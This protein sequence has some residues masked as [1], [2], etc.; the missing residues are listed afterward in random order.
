MNTKTKTIDCQFADRQVFIHYQ[1]PSKISS[2]LQKNQ[3]LYF[4][5]DELMSC[6]SVIVKNVLEYDD[7]FLDQLGSFSDIALKLLHCWHYETPIEFNLKDTLSLKI[8]CSELN[9]TF[10]PKKCNGRCQYCVRKEE[11][12]EFKQE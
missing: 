11:K 2:S 10:V 7:A 9:Q 8:L 5:E 3:R 12:S 4:Y 1:I 6:L